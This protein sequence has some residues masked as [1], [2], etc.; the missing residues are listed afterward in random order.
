V[1]V[2]WQREGERL[3]LELAMRNAKPTIVLT[4]GEMAVDLRKA[5]KRAQDQNTRLLAGNG[6]YSGK[7]AVPVETIEAIICQQTGPAPAHQK[8][9]PKYC[10]V[11]ASVMTLGDCYR[12]GVDIAAVRGDLVQSTGNTVAL[13]DEQVADPKFVRGFVAG[14]MDAC[15]YAI[16]QANVLREA[17]RK[18][19]Y[20]EVSAQGVST[21]GAAADEMLITDA[22]SDVMNHDIRPTSPT[23]L[24]IGQAVLSAERRRA[25]PQLVDADRFREVVR[26]I[27]YVETG[28]ADEPAWSLDLPRPTRSGNTDEVFVAAI[29]KSRMSR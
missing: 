19:M 5:I 6:E 4:H 2:E 13:S 1:A 15:N 7:L 12:F 14:A 27:G 28:K 26:L 24:A 21:P 11:P 3:Q 8:A 20:P 16:G 17:V 10:L 29:D 23:T 18:Q 9:L 25:A 22:V